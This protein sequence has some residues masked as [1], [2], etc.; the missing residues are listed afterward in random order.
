MAGYK[1]FNIVGLNKISV[2]TRGKGNGELQV[3]NDPMGKPIVRISITSS[4]DWT[5]SSAECE[6]ENGI[7]ALWF[8]YEGSDAIDFESFALDNVI[9]I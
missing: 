5:M 1:Y 9:E 8:R 3:L 6:M 4:E 2:N 7:R